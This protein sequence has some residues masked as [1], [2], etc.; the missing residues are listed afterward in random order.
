MKNGEIYEGDTLDTVWPNAEEA[1][2]AVLV[3]RRSE[4]G[5]SAVA[6]GRNRCS[7]MAQRRRAALSSSD[8]LPVVPRRRS[9]GAAAPRPSGHRRPVQVAARRHLPGLA[10]LAGGLR[11]SR[12]QDRRVRRAPGLARDRAPISSSPRSGSRTTSASSHTRSGTSPSLKYDE[13]QRDNQIN[14]KRQQVQILFAKASQASA[15]FNPELLKIPLATVQQWMAA[16]RDS[17]S[18]A[19]PSRTSTASRNTSSTT[20]ASS[21]SR[22]PAGSRRRPTTRT[23]RSRPPT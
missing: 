12:P 13:D 5:A 6:V 2:E 20:R 1:R 19:S 10:R 22:S 7:A 14:A 15:W 8:A 18:T 11:R 16:S 4:V 17:P 21:C 23:R 3:G 9:R